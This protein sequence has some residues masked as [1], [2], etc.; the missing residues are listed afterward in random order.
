M[1]TVV[2]NKSRV[3]AVKIVKKSSDFILVNPQTSNIDI[4]PNSDYKMKSYGPDKSY[5][6]YALKLADGK[7]YVG[8]TGRYNPYDR[9]M[10]HVESVGDGSKWTELHSPLEVVEIRDVGKTSLARVK[11]LERNLTWAYMKIYGTNNVRGG[12]FNYTG[13]L[14]RVGDKIIMGYMFGSF[15]AAFLAMLLLTYIL[16]RH[17]FSWW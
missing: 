16:L 7:Y 15:I 12:V 1:I 6:L 11:A 5:W 9:I 14:L 3:S 8:Y 2:F 17:Y 13:R 10:Q 4:E